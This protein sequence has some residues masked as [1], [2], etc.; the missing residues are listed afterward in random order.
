MSSHANRVNSTASILMGGLAPKPAASTP[1]PQPSWGSIPQQ[2]GDALD[3]LADVIDRIGIGEAN[4][5]FA[6]D[7]EAG[8]G[9]G[10]NA[11]L[12]QHPVLQ[13]ARVHAGAGDVGEY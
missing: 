9:H 3:G 2:R 10:G 5:A 12:L 7:A 8:A 1:P 13:R 11:G 4:V 6:V